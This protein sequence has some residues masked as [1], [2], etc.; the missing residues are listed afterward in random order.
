MFKG[1]Y[2][3]IYIFK[4]HMIKNNLKIV[5]KYIFI[6]ITIIYKNSVTK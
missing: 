3:I 1:Y 2:T 4:L 6:F 5:Y